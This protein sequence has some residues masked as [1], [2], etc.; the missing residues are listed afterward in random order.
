VA[1]REIGENPMRSRRCIRGVFFKFIIVNIPLR[2][3]TWEGE[4]DD[5]TLA[6][7]PA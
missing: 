5:E 1:K 3:Y 4:K 7:R 2:F 6:R